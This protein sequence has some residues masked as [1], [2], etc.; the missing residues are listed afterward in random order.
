MAHGINAKYN[1]KDQETKAAI[2]A[3]AYYADGRT[4]ASVAAFDRA[5]TL[6]N[7]LA[8]IGDQLGWKKNSPRDL[9]NMACTTH[10]TKPQQK[11]TPKRRA[12]KRATTRVKAA[13]AAADAPMPTVQGMDQEVLATTIA[14]AVAQAV[15]AALKASQ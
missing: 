1:G 13:Q 11:A 10:S 14:T 15:L 8:A 5:I 9:V 3:L 4:P 12:A 2:T 6:V 7:K